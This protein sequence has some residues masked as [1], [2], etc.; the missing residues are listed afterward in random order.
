MYVII[1]RYSCPNVLPSA[2]ACKKM[3]MP[4]MF[5][6][7][8]ICMTISFLHV[9]AV[10]RHE[11]TEFTWLFTFQRLTRATFVKCDKI[12][13]QCSQTPGCLCKVGQICSRQQVPYLAYECVTATGKRLKRK[14]WSRHNHRW[15]TRFRDNCCVQAVPSFV[16][17]STR[18]AL[19]NECSACT[20][21]RCTGCVATVS[22]SSSC[23][24]FM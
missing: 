14:C 17:R 21:Q 10:H 8:E 18:Y 22:L 5:S 15:F 11:S 23:N 9:C 12:R 20:I 4:F 7:N 3:Q 2:L 13:R 6:A 19:F 16:C 24:N 1:L